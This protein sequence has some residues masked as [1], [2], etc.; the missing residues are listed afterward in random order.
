[1]EGVDAEGKT[2]I[3]NRLVIK[4]GEGLTVGQ[5]TRMAEE[6]DEIVAMLIKESRQENTPLACG[7]VKNRYIDDEINNIEVY[8]ENKENDEALASYVQSCHKPLQTGP[9]TSLK[10]RHLSSPHSFLFQEISSQH[11]QF[12]T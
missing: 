7:D 4:E 12:P 9:A 3:R 5:V 2:L 10:S 6:Y 11:L 1:M 8:I